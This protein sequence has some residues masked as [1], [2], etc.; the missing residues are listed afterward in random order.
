M[1]TRLMTLGVR[2]SDLNEAFHTAT[3]DP[4]WAESGC[5]AI[6]VP[7]RDIN[8]FVY[9][10]HDNR[11]GS[12]GG[13]PA[14]WDPSGEQP[15]DCLFYDW[16]WRQPLTGPMDFNDFTLPNTLRHQVVEP[17]TRYRLTY[18]ALGLEF[19]LQWSALM[20]PHHIGNGAEEDSV[21]DHYDQPGRMTGSL[22]LDGERFEIDCYSMRDRTWGPHRPGAAR[23]GDYLWAIASGGAHWHAITLESRTPGVDKVIGGY[24]VQDATIGELVQGERRVPARSGGAPARVLFDAVDEHGRTLHAVGDVRT[25]LRWLGRPGR[26]TYW[27]LTDWQW[28]GQR[29]WGA[30]QEFLAR[31]RGRSSLSA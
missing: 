7:E 22:I 11:T 13:G 25:A 27:T 20:A 30:N 1:F 15:H 17:L 21:A 29:G 10:F 12:S 5:F 16:R 19:D 2:A 31:E 23:S 24:L 14:L 4:H 3:D 28:N 9:Y 6:S 8:G 26:L 18:S